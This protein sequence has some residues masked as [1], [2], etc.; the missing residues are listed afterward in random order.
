LAAPA[1]G[2]LTDAVVAGHESA[3]VRAGLAVAVLSVLGLTGHH[4]AHVLYFEL[5]ERAFL[6]LDTEL[7]NL[8]NGAIGI[9]HHERPEWADRVAVV[10]KEL[11]RIPWFGMYALLSMASSASALLLTGVVLA[12]RERVAAAHAAGRG[13]SLITG[14]KAESM[15][16]ARRRRAASSIRTVKHL[17]DL[18][19]TASTAK[20][21]RVLGLQTRLQQRHQHGEPGG[22]PP[23]ATG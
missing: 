13:A 16:A 5:G 9:E 4:F 23:T 8:A 2:N 21:V 14:R 17:L 6:T 15:T 12:R 20:E 1:L 10:R 19:C 11:G 3:A 22:D 18:T 7:I